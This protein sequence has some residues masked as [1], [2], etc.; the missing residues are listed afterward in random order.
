MGKVKIL[1]AADLQ[2]YINGKL[3]A[4]CTGLRWQT[5][6][7]HKPIY[8]IDQITP[9]EIAPGPSSIRGSI[10]C[11]RLKGDGGLEGR[12]VAAPEKYMLLEKYFSL[13]VLDRSTD[14]VILAIEDV[15][16][17]E[18]NWNINSRGQLAGAF[19]FEG[20]GWENETQP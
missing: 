8:G 20:L 4:V 13:A 9:F 15:L 10:E 19:T 7:G 3:F 14:I 2:V 12:G 17:G 11:I 18:Q 5:N 16:V 6:S 1:R